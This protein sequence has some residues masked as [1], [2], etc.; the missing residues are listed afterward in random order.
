MRLFPQTLL[1]RSVLLIALLLTLAHF[2][3]L[4]IFRVSERGPRA[5]Q[6]AQQIVTMV[7]LTRAA[8]ITA[9]PAR[10]IE[11]LRD[12]AQEEGIQ[13]HVGHAN[14]RIAPL[15]DRP[16]FRLVEQE[17]RR[18]LGDDTR[19][20]VSR[21]GIRG[22]WVSFRIDEDDY[23]V[24]MPRSRLERAD[25]LRWIG[26]GAL[27]LALA[28]LG[29]YLIVARINRPLRE[30][31]RA[32]GEI[33]R[34]RTPPP[35]AET[36]PEEIRTLARAFNRMGA[37]LKRMDDERALL[38]AG[39]SHDL[40]TPLSRIRLGLEMLEE[41]GGASLKAG[42]VQDIEDIDAAIGQFLD[43]ARLGEGEA[44]VPEGDLNAI[45]REARERYAVEGADIAARLSPL[46]PLPLRPHAIRRLVTNLLE[47]ALRHGGGQVE[48]ATALEDGKAVIEVRDRGPGI[49]PAEAERMLQPFT[50][51]DAARSGAGTGLGL[52]I[53]ERIARLHGGGIRLLPREG[54]GLRARVELAAGV[55]GPPAPAPTGAPDVPA[56]RAGRTGTTAPPPEPPGA[57]H[58]LEN[59]YIRVKQA[60]RGVFMYNRND[61]FVG[62]SLDL[63]GEWCDSEIELLLRYLRSGDTALDV[64][65]AIGT[66][67]VPFAEAVGPRG[68][69]LAFEP[70][71]LSYQL[72]CGN[73]ALNCL[74]NLHCRQQA[75]GAGRGSV[76]IPQLVPV[77]ANNFGALP[78][79]GHASGD[80]VD[81]VTID[82]FGLESCR[83]IKIDVEGMEADVIR[84]GRGTIS[85]LRPVLF[86][87]NNTIEGAGATIAAILELGYRAWW[88][89]APYFN[90]RNFFGNP[91]NVFAEFQPEANLLCLPQG[92]ESDAP[93][94]IACTGAD[95][96]WRKASERL[97]A[98]RT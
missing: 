79:T 98:G 38:L 85:R 72:L 82:S 73:A 4:E 19:L 11:L 43:F 26:W 97:A 9:D 46:P 68:A 37:D 81:L 47:N 74:T 55:N 54:G 87:E 71:R 96:D 1:W 64:G 94:L 65:A 52:A 25:P 92:C 49:P 36:G 8:L 31:A 7:N 12:L 89:I 17:V 78:A 16:F 60:R 53:V 77:A 15:P 21:D 95:D 10:R 90:E 3:W 62:R 18:Q 75:V 32:A 76:R 93:G 23:W 30:L 57:D 44:V 35:V 2:A 5:R 88:H 83:L 6:V 59:G 69:V 33:G 67:A 13:V 14:E 22:A 70:Q 20:A 91:Q 66:H 51:L 24:F 34:G 42:L 84:G 27:V 56:A 45:V 58:L 61:L 63:Y 48:I 86:V 29:A 80:E 39:V 41:R 50:R 28:L 40:R